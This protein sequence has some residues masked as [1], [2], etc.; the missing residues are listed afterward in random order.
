MTMQA[1][2]IRTIKISIVLTVFAL[3]LR[4]STSDMTY[5]FRHR[6]KLARSMLSMFVIMPVFALCVAAFT[7]VPQPVKVALVILSVGPVPPLLPRRASKASGADD[8]AVGLLFTAALIAIVFVPLIIAI[9][10]DIFGLYARAPISTVASLMLLTV[11]APLIAGVVGHRLM[12]DLAERVSGPLSTFAFVL[13]IVSV[14]PVLWKALPMSF[15]LAHDGSVLAFI[16]FTILGLVAGHFLGGPE[17]EN[18]SV[19]AIATCARHPALAMA[20]ASANFSSKQ[21]AVAAVGLYMVVSI[22]VCIPYSIWRRRQ[23][24]DA[25][26]A[27]APAA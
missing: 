13:L 26:G 17:P 24:V 5:L 27:H 8:Y 11:L 25:G 9:I 6:E 1:L 4:S 2:I 12:P 3:G 14:L 18:R 7:N 19:L 20:I 15:A 10:G 22:L 21:D 16:V 23:H